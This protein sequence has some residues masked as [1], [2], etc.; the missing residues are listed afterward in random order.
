[1]CNMPCIYLPF[2]AKVL[3]VSPSVL[4]LRTGRCF[5]VFLQFRIG[6]TCVVYGLESFDEH[7]LGLFYVVERD[8]AVLEETVGHLAIILFTSDDMLSSVYVGSERE[9]A[10]TPSAIIRM[11]CSRVKGFGPG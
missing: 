4:A 10:S 1:M 3:V 6:N 9:A 7:E 11:A 5:F 2:P 8:G